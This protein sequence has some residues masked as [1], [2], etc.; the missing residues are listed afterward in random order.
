MF[1][2]QT[3][4]DPNHVDDETQT[5]GDN[6]PVDVVEIG[7]K[8]HKRGDVVPVMDLILIDFLIAVWHYHN[9]DL[10]LLTNVNCFL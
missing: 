8:V 9:Y 2:L 4:E 1:I 10:P 7:S 5:K 3:W 6:D